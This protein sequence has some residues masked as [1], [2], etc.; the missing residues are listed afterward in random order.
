N[1][2]GFEVEERML[3]FNG[4]LSRGAVHEPR[5]DVLI[6]IR[7]GAKKDAPR[8][9]GINNTNS[10]AVHDRRRT[11]SRRNS[12]ASCLRSMSRGSNRVKLNF[13]LTSALL[14]R[15]TR[16]GTKVMSRQ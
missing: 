7:F 6:P 14:R 16:C 15:L 11:I 10:L 3:R 12:S 8:P 13:D 4:E 5:L 2:N 9:A 1:E